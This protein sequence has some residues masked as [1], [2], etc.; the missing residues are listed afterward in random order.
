MRM[1]CPSADAAM[2]RWWARRCRAAATPTT[3]RAL[4][5][6]NDLVDVRDALPAVRVPTLVVHRARRPADPGRGGPLPRPAHRRRPVGR[7]GRR[8]SLRVRRPGPDPRSDRS[9]PHRATRARGD[10]VGV[11][12]G[13]RARRPRRGALADLWLMTAAAGAAASGAALGAVR[14]PGHR[15]PGHATPSSRRSDASAGRARRRARP[16]GAGPGRTRRHHGV[17]AGRGCALRPDLGQFR[18][19]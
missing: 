16:A 11:G 5:R 7:A 9:L 8:R 13:G 15:G 4:M 2:T 1:R 3:V 14:W 10:H 19:A 18:G 12:G 6:M 17:A